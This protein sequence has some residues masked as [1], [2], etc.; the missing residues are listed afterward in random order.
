ME[1]RPMHPSPEISSSGQSWGYSCSSP[2]SSHA[3][4]LELDMFWVN[5]VVLPDVT[6]SLKGH[7]AQ[8]SDL[9]GGSEVAHAFLRVCGNQK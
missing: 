3:V 9:G 8:L 4:S 7:Q 6:V 5:T 2:S 1:I